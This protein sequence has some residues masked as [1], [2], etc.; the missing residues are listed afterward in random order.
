MLNKRNILIPQIILGLCLAFSNAACSEDDNN[1]DFEVV[2]RPA[3]VTLTLHKYYDENGASNQF[4]W[5]EN[6]NGVLYVASNGYSAIATPLRPGQVSSLFLFKVKAPSVST[7]VSYYPTDADVT[8]A[9]GTVSL[10][11]PQVQNGTVSPLLIGADRQAISSY[12]GC[13]IDLK[14]YPALLMVNVS[15]GNYSVESIEIQANAGENIAGKIT[16][17]ADT[18]TPTPSA[19]TV[20]VKL[21]TPVNCSLE[22]TTI[23]A[24]IA[25][26][27]LTKGYT[28][29]VNTTDG[30]S[31]NVST[32]EPVVFESGELYTTN[33]ATDSQPPR[34]IIAGSNKIH[35]INVA[36]CMNSDY[37]AGLEWTW[38]ATDAAS[39]LGL[40]AA[41]CDHIDDCKPVDNGTKFLISSS[42]NWVVLLDRTTKQVLFHAEQCSNAHSAELLPGNRIAVAC[43]DGTSSTHNQVQIYDINRPNTILFS[44]PLTSGHGVVWCETTN[45]LYAIGS[46]QLMVF[47]L[48]D[49]DT[50]APQLKLEKTITT[51]QSSNHDLTLADSNTLVVAGVRAYLFDVNT[52]SFTEMPHFA[53]ST[54]LKS[55]NY[56]PLT[57]ELWYTDATVPEGTQSWSTHTLRYATDPAAT[58]MA[59]TIRITDMDVYKVRV[60]NW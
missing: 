3:S 8:V 57:S 17:D 18:W 25:P 11:I 10:E 55:V 40:T 35:V 50:S 15:R 39:V 13:N 23:A 54:Q 41:R 48:Q 7:V 60:L 38:D 51:P 43:S 9:D 27:T 1:G 47:S 44:Y 28:I 6:D 20:S 45:R 49:W 31:F 34:L 46:K 12:E 29:T 16:I 42:Y 2:D 30:T 53:A 5:G 4:K 19:Q 33:D 52:E 32:E 24:Q 36:Q 56:N 58:S 59:G 21:P 37:K 26:V 14:Q 22:G